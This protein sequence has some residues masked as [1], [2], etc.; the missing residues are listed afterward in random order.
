MLSAEQIAKAVADLQRHDITK[1]LYRA[2]SN[3][4]SI[5]VYGNA[6]SGKN[7]VFS[8]NSQMLRY[9]DR[10]VYNFDDKKDI[11]LFLQKAT[12]SLMFVEAHYSGTRRLNFPVNV[13]EV[14]MQ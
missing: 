6:T 7:K 8:E 10:H 9:Y 14:F 2:V 1:K 3:N 12:D 13:V 4:K 11:Q 5:V